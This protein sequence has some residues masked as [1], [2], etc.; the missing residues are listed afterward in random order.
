MSSIIEGYNYDIFISYRQKDNKGDRW[1]SEFVEA[2]KTELESTFKEE[3]SV[4]FDI[5]PHDGLLE[6]H[7][8]DASLKDKLKCLVF[9]PIISRTFC[10]PKS[11]A[12]EHEF[13]AFVELASQDQFGLK[14]KLPNGN[15]SS[16]VLPVRIHELDND[17]IKLCESVLESVLRGV[18]FIYKSAGVNRPLRAKEEK[19]HDNL[20]NTIYRD[21]INKVANAINEII[22]SIRK[23]QTLNDKEQIQDKEPQKR[24]KKEERIKFGKTDIKKPVKEK[25]YRITRIFKIRRWGVSIGIILAVL[26]VIIFWYIWP[27][28]N[29]PQIISK[30]FESSVAVL[31]FDDISDM[32][33]F[34]NFAIGATEN[35]ISRL[36]RI[37]DLKV[38]PINESLKYKQLKNSTRAICKDNDV[39]MVLQGS[40]KADSGN[41]TLEVELIDG[42]RD[43]V[44]WKQSK[45]DRLEN[46]LSIQDE[47]VSEV[48]R[49]INIKYSSYQVQK[50]VGIKPTKN[51]KAYELLLKGN[52]ELTKWT[53]EN[54]KE[55]LIY[56]SRALD[57]DQNYIEALA[58]SALANL[59]LAYFY[60]NERNIIESIKKDAKKTLSLEEDNEIALMSM[61]GYYIMKISS[62]Q[63]LHLLEYRDMIIKLKRL[64]SKNPSSPMAFF[65]LAEYY[66]L[67]KKDLFKASEY[68]KLS[69]A[70]CEKI[71]QGDPSN[72]I[73][74]GI[75]AQSAGILGQIEFKTGNFLEAIK[76]T[77]YSIRLV[78][79]ILRTYIQLANFYFDTDQ[80]VK[81]RTVFD[82]AISNVINAKD[83]GY[84][85]LIRGRY[86]M[87]EGKYKE[88]E[89]YWADSM[90][91]L[92]EPKNPDYDYALLYRFVM[93]NKLGNSMMADSLIHDR[94]KTVGINSWPEPIIYFFAGSLKEEDLIRLAKRDWQKCE[95]F[96]FLGEKYLMSRNLIEAKK[97]FEECV[98]T[99]ENDY[100]EYDMSQAELSSTFQLIR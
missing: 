41:I 17:D 1:V 36:A 79:G 67:L 55:S 35:L 7:D 77:E 57:I 97:Y 82:Q 84:I 65:G 56:Y 71:L 44:L 63:K 45:V 54:L 66:R 10:D 24:V 37:Q 43:I 51:F 40:V 12:W 31:V 21:Q 3:I 100:I 69:L 29:K 49:A 59:L 80:P 72:G 68:F 85:E 25:I 2:L 34:K 73:I 46:I 75:A 48:A 15:V 30:N 4:Y 32:Q 95:A 93:L 58:N 26:L 90:T 70:Q 11:F 27:F 89:Q 81:G 76:D 19:P 18:E 92:R 50:Q 98:N 13:K 62:G 39:K 64:I 5:N 8:V 88:A 61:E 94:L 38:V 83:R 52:A 47:I 78:P 16:R 6:T 28:L 87:V 91:N 22:R 14:I 23:L 53:Y 9:I 86:S 99:K 33:G 42:E 60:E 20:N 96:F 74:L